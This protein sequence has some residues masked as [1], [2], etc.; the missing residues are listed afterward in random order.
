MGAKQN[1]AH[2]K[3][4][5]KMHKRMSFRKRGCNLKFEKLVRLGEVNFTL[6]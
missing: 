3:D 5:V 1:E 6:C 2:F 4:D